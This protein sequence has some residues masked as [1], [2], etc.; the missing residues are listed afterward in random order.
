MVFCANVGDARSSGSMIIL[1]ENLIA[2][3][4]VDWA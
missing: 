3:L 1:A 4:R 2:A